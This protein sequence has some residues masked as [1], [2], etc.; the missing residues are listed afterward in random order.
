M[1]EWHDTPY[2]Y[3]RYKDNLIAI[4]TLVVDDLEYYILTTA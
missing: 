2:V 3:Y 1:K 4:A